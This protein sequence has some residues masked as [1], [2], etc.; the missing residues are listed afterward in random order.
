LYI[1]VGFDFTEW[2]QNLN[3]S[4]PMGFAALAALVACI[5]L[6]KWYLG[7]KQILATTRDDLSAVEG[8][9]QEL[10][11]KLEAVG[12]QQRLFH[13]LV[14]DLSL[15]SEQL[16]NRVKARNIP[17]LL[18]QIVQRNFEPKQAVV[19]MRRRDEDSG[20]LAVVAVHPADSSIKQGAEIAIGQ[21]ELGFVAETQVTMNRRDLDRETSLSA[22]KLR[23]GRFPGFRPELAAPLVFDGET[24]GVI[25]ISGSPY[26]NTDAK[27]ALRLI[28]QLGAM[29][30]KNV[31]AY[32]QMKATAEIDGLTRIFNKRYM[33]RAL[34][35][36]VY[37]AQ[38]ELTK[39]SIFLFDIDNFKNYN[40]V[41]GHV[42]GDQLLRELAL[43]VQKN[44]REDDVFGRFGGE[45][46]L[47]ILS[48]T[49]VSDALK[50]ADKL[51]ELIVREG[52][53]HAEKQPLGVLSVSG[54]VATYP[55]A[56]SDST[57]LLNAADEALYAAKKKGRNRVLAAQD[58]YLS[59]GRPELEE[60]RELQQLPELVLEETASAD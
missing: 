30:L 36:R 19:L 26:K 45:E 2:T 41:N 25:A 33:T 37:Q 48:D 53:P 14:S 21:G 56:A 29:T 54:G 49:N 43:F 38:Q 34:G 18:L 42:A 51:R 8:H 60:L 10:Q 39:L 58:P 13:H 59:D 11:D 1:F 17:S 32:S 35:E 57:G 20:R 7:L 16:H 44:V 50:V 12:K 52:F 22:G 6:L 31:A 5:V 24:L 4:E 3:L 40:D 9:K 23:G 46:F 47:L 28:A 55:T 27:R 15:L